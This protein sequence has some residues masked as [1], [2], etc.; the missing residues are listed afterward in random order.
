MYA[1]KKFLFD[2]LTIRFKN[3]ASKIRMS[4]ALMKKKLTVVVSF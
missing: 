2:A 4:T 1:L 3:K